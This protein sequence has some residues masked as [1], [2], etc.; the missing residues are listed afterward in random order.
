MTE[1]DAV[2]VRLEGDHA[3]V[4][5]AGAGSACGA[6]SHKEGCPSSASGAVL[7]GVSGQPSHLMRLAN[8]I[9]ARPGDAVVIRMA[10]GMMLRA[11][12]QAYGLPLLLAL[13]GATVAIALTGSEPIAMAGVLLGLLAG[14]LFMR[15]R[16]LDSGRSEPILSISFKRVSQNFHEA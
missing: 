8:T 15:G 10:D 5:A 3:W 12:W 1:T 2:V 16:G 4:R 9:H 14:F 11:V 7:D 13:A 6:C